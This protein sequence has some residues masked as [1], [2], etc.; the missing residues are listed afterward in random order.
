MSEEIMIVRVAKAIAIA[1]GDTNWKS[2]LTTAR[3]AVKAMREPT[4][5]NVAGSD[6]RLAGLG[7]S[8]G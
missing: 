5:R 7:I 3:A 6:A 8:A 4:S 2:H 1:T